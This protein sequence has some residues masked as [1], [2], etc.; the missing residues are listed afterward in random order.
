MLLSLL[1]GLALAS[2]RIPLRSGGDF[3]HDGLCNG[4]ER[5]LGTNPARRDTDGDGWTDGEEVAWGSDPL[6]PRSVP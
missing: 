2:P 6:G 4:A 5:A 3:D 1:A